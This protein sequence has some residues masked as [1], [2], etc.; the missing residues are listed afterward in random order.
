M[1]K[2][3]SPVPEFFFRFCRVPS[4]EVPKI[5]KKVLYEQ[6]GY[7]LKRLFALLLF[8]HE[9]NFSWEIFMAR[10]IEATYV[11][12]RGVSLDM[13]IDWAEIDLDSGQTLQSEIAE[14]AYLIMEKYQQFEPASEMIQLLKPFASKPKDLKEQ[15]RM[16]DL[17]KMVV[18]VNREDE[19]QRQWFGALV[20]SPFFSNDKAVECVSNWSHLC[21]EEDVSRVLNLSLKVNHKEAKKLAIKCASH[22]SLSQLILVVTRHFYNNRFV[23]LNSDVLP[24]IVLLFNKLKDSESMKENVIF[25]LLLLILQ[26]PDASISF[27]LTE[28]VKNTFYVSVL[29]ECF[30]KLKDILK[31]HDIGVNCLQK[32]MKTCPPNE[33]NHGSYVKLLQLFVDVNLFTNETL[34]SKIIN[35]SLAEYIKA[36]HLKELQQILKILNDLQISIQMKETSLEFFENLFK[37]LRMRTQFMDHR[38]SAQ[39][40]VQEVVILINNKIHINQGGFRIA[41]EN[42]NDDK[43]I[44][45]YQRSICELETNTSLLQSLIDDFSVENH[46]KAVRQLM[47]ILPSCVTE[48]WISICSEI[49]L[50][51]S[52]EKFLSIMHDMMLLVC[53]FCQS[54]EHSDNFPTLLEALKYCLR[55][56]GTV[57][58]GILSSNSIEDEVIVTEV[59]VKLLCYL[60]AIIKETEGLNLISLMTERSLKNLGQ[61]KEFVTRICN[62]KNKNICQIIAQKILG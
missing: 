57:I 18:M 24:E 31:I 37:I 50:K 58:Q 21:M 2:M 6:T 47:Q 62:I 61:D 35:P 4:T 9:N 13:F 34:I 19:N 1:D 11:V 43:F 14:N 59:L 60:P 40:V 28:C 36:D 52:N 32:A 55:Q 7:I 16:A 54:Q 23:I 56:L 17:D 33:Q 15:I 49:V 48:E 20:F 45:Y 26:N 12:L 41:I 30:T 53:Q 51:S 22:L 25:E 8:C 38:T 27:I 46:T 3:A 44:S 39:V 29:R 5:K 42:S 10:L